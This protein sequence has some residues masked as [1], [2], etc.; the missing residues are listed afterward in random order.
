M[1]FYS[2]KKLHLLFLLSFFT[3]C[4]DQPKVVP[5]K[6]ISLVIGNPVSFGLNNVLLFPVGGNYNPDITDAEKETENFKEDKSLKYSST[7]ASFSV[8]TSSTLYDRN[9]Q[10]E[11]INSHEEDFDIRNILFYNKLT[12]KTY[13]LTND[14]LHILSF[15][16]H[17]EYADSPLIFFRVVKKDVNEDGKYNSKDAVMLF[18]SRE[19]GKHLIQVTPENEQFFDYF[20]YP[21][22]KTILVKTAID[23]DGNKQFDLADE[24]NF[25]EMKLN[26]PAFGREIFTQGLKDSLKHLMNKN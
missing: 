20:Y 24:T 18:V 5:A 19:N 10:S 2:M 11:W 9:A 26:A 7:S 15:A 12:G 22:T 13:P 1:H 23:I 4:T 6:N 16:I 8:N 17:Y 21:E 25:R 3:A 14:T